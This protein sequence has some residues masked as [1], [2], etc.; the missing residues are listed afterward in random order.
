MTVALCGHWDHEGEC[1]WPHLSTIE[2]EPHGAY[3]L[4]VDFDAPVE[5]VDEVIG[6]I[7]AGLETRYL[8]GP[9]GRETTWT[10][11]PL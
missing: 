8:R 11:Q 2:E 3:R 10:V 5:E 4:R 6:A 7:E 9:D 1:R